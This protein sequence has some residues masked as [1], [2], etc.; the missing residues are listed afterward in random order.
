LFLFELK[1]S[2]NELGR[3]ARFKLVLVPVSGPGVGSGVGPGVGSM[4]LIILP[5]A[6][7]WCGELDCC[8]ENNNLNNQNH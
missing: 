1:W 7:A 3:L 8:V 6:V 2:E 4:L 5:V